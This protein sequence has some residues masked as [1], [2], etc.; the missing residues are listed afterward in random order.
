MR[1]VAAMTLCFG[2]A[3]LTGLAATYT[4]SSP[5]DSGA[6]TLRQ[7]LLNANAAGATNTIVFNLPGPGPFTVNVLSALP[8]IS[9]PIV[10]DGTTQPGFATTPIVELNGASAGS[11]VAGLYITAGN[12]T[13][14]GLVI[15][16]FAGSGILLESGDSNVIQGNFIGTDPAGTSNLGNALFG[17]Q[18]NNSSSN[19]IGGSLPG[20]ANTI[21]FNGNAAVGIASG[22]GNLVRGNSTFANGDP[23]IDLGATG[24]VLPNTPGGPHIGPNNLQNFPVLTAVAASG[25]GA[26]VHGSLNSTPNTTFQIDLYDSPNADPSG[27]GEGKTY[28]SSISVKTDAGGNGSFSARLPDGLPVNSYLA[29]T[30]TDPA[31]NTSEFSKC[32]QFVPASAVAL[33][34]GVTTSSNSVLVGEQFVYS[35]TMTNSGTN[36]AGGVVVTDQLPASMKYVYSVASQGTSLNSA[37]LVTCNIGTLPPGGIA[38][39]QIYAVPQSVGIFT[40]LATLSQ[41]EY[42]LGSLQATNLL[43]TTAYLPTPPVITL[44]PVGQLLNLGGL[45]NLVVGA[46]GPPGIRYQWR[47]NG[48]NIPGATNALYSVLSLLAPDCGD[49]T[50]VVSDEFGAIT[51]DTA[52]VVLNG[53]LT[54]PASD[55]FASRGPY[56]NL[57]NLISFSN[58][59]A[60]SEPGE[61]LHAGVPGGK[62]VWFTWTPLLSGAATLTTAGSSF[63]TLLAVYTGNSLTNLTEVASDDD[64]GGHYT[65]RVVFNAVGGTTYI[66]AV[67]GAYGAEGKIILNAS[68]ALL[69]T[70]PHM[71]SQPADQVVGFGGTA[72]FSAQA[73]GPGLSYQWFMNDLAIAGATSTSLH[74]TNVSAQQV[75]LYTVR[76]SSSAGNVL[77]RYASLQISLLDGNVNGNAI[78]RDKFQ[79]AGQALSTIF[80]ASQATPSIQRVSGTQKG[81]VKMMGAGTSRGYSSTQIFS[82][83]K[84]AAQAGEPNHCGTAGGASSWTSVQAVDNGVMTID[85]DGSNFK[86]IL[87]VYTG[88]GNDFS[89]LVSVACDVGSGRGGSNSMVT[90]AATSNTTYYVGVD[91]VY[92]AYGT[93]VLNSNL[94][95]PPSITSQP[96]SQSASPGANISLSAS[97]T[98][99]PAP[100]CQWYY[101]GALVTG[102]TNGVFTITNFQAAK[103]G[104]YQMVATNSL[105]WSVTSP[106]YMVFNSGLHLDS[107]AQ[108]GPNH[109]FQMRL[110]GTANT[111]YVIQASTNLL[112][113][114]ALATNTV[115]NGLW[116]FTDL[117]S[118]N[119]PGRY[120]RAVPGQ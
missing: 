25:A 63:D 5:A 36:L 86:T 116:T 78:A 71:T 60:T 108:V 83:Y 112:D 90:F 8:I 50:V 54:L 14:R 88:N 66:I 51:S 32:L 85:T 82:T 52:L 107:S 93:V 89:S 58:E 15:N 48:A 92:G 77:S 34:F 102:C 13:V 3:P 59:G 113:W 119:F 61:P 43:V 19:I 110:V 56:L 7:A 76:A 18:I 16:R 87:A 41:N 120:Y 44:Q 74:I 104:N 27:F 33:S 97:A 42:N 94:R 40:N 106:A 65:S 45:L 35:L 75:G 98:G 100:A 69:Q 114:V 101:N 84:G 47:L 49:Y 20:S 64:S 37:G 31:D 115:P 11:G 17:I 57:L 38:T 24:V 39:V 2:L 9:S 68:Q 72:N 29:A 105:G 62:S 79:A 80:G 53:L 1:V 103:A 111:S 4:V 30:A 118:T 70:L 99:H 10:I 26:F 96:S 117:Q 67:D 55:N 23:A 95:V 73:A 81:S 22:T 21:A 12:S 46:A 91:G 28:L 6:G 109:L